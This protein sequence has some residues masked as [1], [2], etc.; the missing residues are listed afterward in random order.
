MLSRRLPVLMV[1]LSLGCQLQVPVT[2]TKGTAPLARPKP[3]PSASSSPLIEVAPGTGK[4]LGLVE[5]PRVVD[6][7]ATV[8]E[9][10]GKVKL[11]T[12]VKIISDNGGGVLSNNSASVISN[13]GGSI[14]TNG[15]NNLIGKVKYRAQQA[16]GQSALPEVLLAD[17]QIEVLDAAGNVLVDKDKKPITATTDQSGNYSFKA[18]LPAEN[19]ILRVR[20]FNG[21]QLFAITTADKRSGA[22]TVNLDTASSLGAAYVLNKYVKKKQAVLD[23]LPGLEADKLQADMELARVHLADAALGYDPQEL[24]GFVDQM[25]AKSTALD[26]TIVRIQALLLAGQ[27]NL[28]NGL[29][30]TQVALATP[31]AIAGDGKGTYYLCESTSG[32]VRQ[33]APDGTV[34]VFAGPGGP[35][36]RDTSLGI[37]LDLARGPDGAL[38]FARKHANEIFKLPA[39]GPMVRVAGRSGLAAGALGQKATESGLNQIGQLSFGPDGLLYFNDN[40]NRMLMVD[41]EGNLQRITTPAGTIAGSV[42][43]PDGAFWLTTYDADLRLYRKKPGEDWALLTTLPP[44]RAKA[45]REHYMLPQA[46]GTLLLSGTRDHRVYSVSAGGAFTPFAGTGEQGYD[47]DNGPASSARL[48]SPIGLWREADGATYVADSGNGLV[49]RIDKTGVITTVAG[50]R[51]VTQVGDAL[52]VSISQPGGVEIDAEGRILVVESASHTIKR[53]NGA[54][55]TVIAGTTLG[56][57]GDG[58]PATAAAF[59]APTGLAV[60]NG[61]LFVLDSNNNRLRKIDKNGVVTTIAGVSK[62]T[63]LKASMDPFE[64][65]LLQ[66]IDVAVSPEGDPYWTETWDNQHVVRR[67][68]AGKVEMV[69]GL[70]DTKG[71]DGGDGG[72]ATSAKLNFPFGLTFDKEGNLY[73]ADTGNMRIRKVDKQGIISTYAGISLSTLLARLTGSPNAKTELASENNVPALEAAIAGPAGLAFDDKGNLY[74]SEVSAA[75]LSSFG[76]SNTF[77]FDGLL[78]DLPARIRKVTP[79]GKVVNV[80]GP[81]TAL[82]SSGDNLLVY[83]FGLMY[84]VKNGRLIVADSALNQLKVLKGSF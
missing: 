76:F 72:P 41:G 30:A 19:L 45:L 40:G 18:A 67:L 32:R 39:T 23:L 33:I 50:T 31:A 49:R 74:F 14:V 82:P 7:T 10:I 42:V 29:L 38:Y 21:G 11:V 2:G 57:S 1:A 51:A 68:R 20:L 35:A 8:A 77:A 75:N 28:G 84:D 17:A 58:G 22:Q 9:L 53:L 47:G 61:E 69:A 54:S 83:P 55:L 59:T 3:S 63:T 34:S 80:T 65:E 12:R 27:E 24:V 81:G 37:L 36:G 79:D 26:A 13:N 60:H 43:G 62:H 52:T 6:A 64:T 16:G 44:E 70:I 4:P 15:G 25:R 66:P 56:F 5:P 46:D 48:N 73:I 78:P 71:G